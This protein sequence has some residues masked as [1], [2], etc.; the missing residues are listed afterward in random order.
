VR[1]T[2]NKSATSTDSVT[3]TVTGHSRKAPTV[4]PSA[5]PTSGLAPLA[6][7]FQ[8]NA[9]DPDGTVVAYAWDFDNSD[10]LQ[11]ESTVA[12]PSHT[13]NRAG[14]YVATVTAR[15]DAGN[16]ATGSVRVL[17]RSEGNAPP[18][19]RITAQPTQGE[20]PLLVSFDAVADDPDNEAV[21]VTWDFDLSDGVQ[22]EATGLHVTHTFERSG[23]YTVLATARDPS[24][25]TA[26]DSATIV[27]AS[28]GTAKGVDEGPLRINADHPEGRAPLRVQFSV[29]STD[30]RIQPQT[31]SW[32]F[33]D[34]T[35]LDASQGP[36]HVFDRSGRFT[37]VVRV[38]D[39]NGTTHAA[40]TE[41]V[42]T[43]KPQGSPGP[44]LPLLVAAIGLAAIMARR[45][46][47]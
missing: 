34:G 47:D 25:A 10:G 22:K 44:A 35:A 18:T 24:G 21:N 2:D 31:Y 17:V 6:V 38:T 16:T 43:A 20:S 27:V 29:S 7:Q 30:P 19:I 41:I 45:R 36:T 8:A 11:N 13:Y 1:V 15:D 39:S 42:V 28:T 12:D 40:H 3:I 46:R 4:A 37:V 32:D 5:S 26:T 23:K 33:G 14:S 9:Q